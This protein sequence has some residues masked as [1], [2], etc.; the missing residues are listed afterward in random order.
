M[1]DDLFNSWIRTRDEL[2]IGERVRSKTHNSVLYGVIEDIVGGSS[3]E[4]RVESHDCG[5]YDPG[6][7]ARVNKRLVE[8][9]R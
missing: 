7:L 1:E 3:I 2:K 8:V 4:I 9:W 5:F 6:D